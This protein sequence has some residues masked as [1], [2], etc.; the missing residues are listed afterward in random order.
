MPLSNIVCEGEFLNN[1]KDVLKNLFNIK[2]KG[3]PIGGIIFSIIII[4]G[5]GSFLFMLEMGFD[6][7]LVPYPFGTILL[8]YCICFGL[9]I[10]GA[11]FYLMFFWEPKKL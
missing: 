7:R 3:Q 10:F 1:M 4:M 8:I 6:F 11:W 9:F 2:F 5:I